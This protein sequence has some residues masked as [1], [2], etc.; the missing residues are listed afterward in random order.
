MGDEFIKLTRSTELSESQLLSH[1]CQDCWDVLRQHKEAVAIPVIAATL[2]VV[3]VLGKLGAGILGAITGTASTAGKNLLNS[4]LKA[5]ETKA[6]LACDAAS[7]SKMH[8]SSDNLPAQSIVHRI[9]SAG[10]PGQAELGSSNVSIAEGLSLKAF[11]LPAYE[12]LAPAIFSARP[13]FELGPS[14]RQFAPGENFVDWVNVDGDYR[15]F[16]VH[17]PSNFNPRR[18]A[19][20]VVAMD[21]FLVKPVNPFRG[22]A[23][24]N[25][26]NEQSDKLGFVALYPVPKPRFGSRIFSWNESD[27]ST[28]FMGV[29]DYSDTGYVK[30]AMQKLMTDVS[31]DPSKIFALGFSQGALQMHDL[32]SKSAQGTFSAIASVAGTITEK[33]AA[34]PSGTRLLVIHSMGD[35]T[36]PY[37]GGAG[38]LPFIFDRMGWGYAG[39]SEPAAQVGRYLDANKISLAPELALM[40]ELT[41]KSWKLD[42]GPSEP[43]VQEILLDEKYG[44][45]F[46]GRVTI[47]QRSMIS[48]LNGRIPDKSILD[49]KTWITE[50]FFGLTGSFR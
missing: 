22:M 47:G 16:M 10:S 41:V 30:T 1:V 23:L 50:D 36:L 9:A 5:L 49:A 20:L 17:I 33:L 37:S 8:W 2:A 24:S 32:V 21:G 7:L 14:A 27:G 6:S 44:H 26:I 13:S 31:I 42:K 35:P 11:A 4:E 39:E 28:N 29:R 38:K 3:P 15:Q 18:A 19:P 46:P 45:T 48:R 34:P 12:P 43:F 40:P 25:G